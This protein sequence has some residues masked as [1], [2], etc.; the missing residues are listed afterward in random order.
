MRFHVVSLPH[1]NTTEAFCVCAYTEKVRKFCKMMHR[2]GHTVYL[3]AGGQNA[4]EC[5]EWVTCATEDERRAAVGDKHYV[6]ASFDWNLP[7]WQKFNANAIEAMKTR[8][9]PQDFICLIGGVAQKQIADAFPHHQVVEFGIGYGGTFAKYKVWESY[10]WMHTCYGAS[11]NDPHTLDGRW[12]DAV[13]PNSFEPEAFPF[14]AKKDDYFLFIG[15]MVD[16]KGVHIAADVCERLRVPL[17]LAGIGT[18]P[19]YGQHV[20]VV[21]P[22]ARGKLMAGAAAVFVPTLYIEPF[23]GVAVEAMLCG[24]PVITTDWGAFTETVVRG[25]SGFRCRTLREFVSA[26]KLVNTLD[27]HKIRDYAM[28]RYTLDVVGKQYERYFTRLGTLWGE[29]WYAGAA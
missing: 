21:G 9:Q 25:V 10:A 17:I 13:I 28:K 1:T 12:F 24:T 6:E 22:E 2:L 14:R 16:R 26:A 18:P 11:V 4:A 15:R 5:Y 3:Y 19:K 7:H 29:G 27:P 23:G 20:G 8:V